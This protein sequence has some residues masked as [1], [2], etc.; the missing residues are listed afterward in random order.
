LKGGVALERVFSV[1]DVAKRY[2]VELAKFQDANGLDR[3]LPADSQDALKGVKY[4][5]I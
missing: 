2:G 5:V 4:L 3:D 1:K